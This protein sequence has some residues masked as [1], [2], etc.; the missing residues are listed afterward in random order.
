MLL[1]S[2]NDNAAEILIYAD[3]ILY[4]SDQNITS[5]NNAKIIWQNQIITSDLIV[6]NQKNKKYYFPS[7]LVYKD[8][9]GNL[10][11]KIYLN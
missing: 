9:N 6:Y 8:Q 5:K 3:E 2:K 1:L 11:L 4:D 10:G 7:D